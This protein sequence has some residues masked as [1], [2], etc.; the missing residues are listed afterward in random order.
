MIANMVDYQVKD[1]GLIEVHF[2]SPDPSPYGQSDFYVVI[3]TAESTQNQVQLKT[4]LTNRLNDKYGSAVM[5]PATGLAKGQG[6]A[7]LNVFK[8]QSITVNT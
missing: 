8:G 2:V 1:N 4:T 6:V 7:A 5:D 3:T